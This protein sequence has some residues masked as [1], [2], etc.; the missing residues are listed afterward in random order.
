[1]TRCTVIQELEEFMMNK[2]LNYGVI[3]FALAALALCLPALY[4]HA[5]SVGQAVG[6]VTL[7]TSSNQPGASIPDLGSKV[8]AVFYTDPDQKDLN[9][10]LR[11]YLKAKN[12]PGDAYRGLGVV[13]LK[14]T[15]I[16]NPVVRT[17]IR[18]RERKFNTVVLTD[19]DHL[20][21]KA[22]ELGDVNDRDMVIIIGKDMRILYLNGGAVR[23]DEMQKVADI[24]SGALAGR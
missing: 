17:I 11:D 19:P 2:K 21:G 10:P 18:Q 22:W 3:I 23:G 5:A 24:I 8:L 14:D 1:M 16:P 13:N 4:L 6:N 7:F 20:L 15:W 12:Y 9:E